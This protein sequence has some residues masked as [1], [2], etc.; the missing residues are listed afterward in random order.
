MNFIKMMLKLRL[1]YRVVDI[2]MAALCQCNNS[3]SVVHRV[4]A[5]RSAIFLYVFIYKLSHFSGS[6]ERGDEENV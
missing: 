4:I 1:L 6:K 2:F 3:F 5:G